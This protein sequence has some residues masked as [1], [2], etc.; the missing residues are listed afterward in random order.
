MTVPLR[1]MR[2]G[3]ERQTLRALAIDFQE[4]FGDDAEIAFSYALRQH[5]IVEETARQAARLAR[6][7]AAGETITQ[8]DQSALDSASEVGAADK[9]IGPG[10]LREFKVPADFA[11]P[12]GLLGRLLGY[13]SAVPST[14]TAEAQPKAPPSRAIQFLRAHPETAEKF[15]LEYGKGM[16]KKILDAYPVR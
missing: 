10:P 6:K 16:A 14:Q 1:R 3:E 2:P 5:R 4:K 7:M 8:A 9:A 12:R 11:Q 13:P 15:D